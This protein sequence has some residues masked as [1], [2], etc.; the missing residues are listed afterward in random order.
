[1][2]RSVLVLF[3]FILAACSSKTNQLSY[4]DRYYYVAE[5]AIDL[6]EFPSL[7]GSP[8]VTIS[9]GDT[10]STTN[11][12][13]VELGG[14]IPIDY[15]GFRFYSPAA[16]ARL[17]AKTKIK[18]SDDKVLAAA[19]YE[20]IQRS[21]AD[22]KIVQLAQVQEDSIKTL[23]RK[24]SVW[25]TKALMGIDVQADNYVYAKVITQLSTASIVRISRYDYNYWKVWLPNGKTGFV[26]VGQF[27]SFSRTSEPFV[28]TKYVGITHNPGGE[29]ASYAESLQEGSSR[30]ST[31]TTGAT[32]HTGPRGGRFY[33]NSHGNKT[34]IRRK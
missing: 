12:D 1:M 18:P 17:I 27:S 33:Y 10:V 11:V 14:R 20:T 7:H 4:T 2:S 24:D 29:L 23:I 8:L 3:L 6:Y 30:Y 25:Y 32:I 22:K 34:Y 15:K 5:E 31:P 9:A 16:K 26:R 21:N 19:S 28:S 13:H